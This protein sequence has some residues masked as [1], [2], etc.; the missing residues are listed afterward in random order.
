MTTQWLD[1]DGVV[2]ID[3]VPVWSPLITASN[4][5]TELLTAVYS[6]CAT[7]SQQQWLNCHCLTTL[8]LSSHHVWVT[9]SS[10]WLMEQ[11]F[12]CDIHALAQFWVLLRMQMTVICTLLEH[13][14]IKYFECY[15][16]FSADISTKFI[17]KDE[18]F[19]V[20]NILNNDKNWCILLGII[21]MCD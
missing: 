7:G 3:K 20:I 9:M 8:S 6:H 5:V 14:I 13:R 2:T 16:W 11:E 4:M 10:R 19:K 21:K 17:Q 15:N 18:H 1:S 12:C